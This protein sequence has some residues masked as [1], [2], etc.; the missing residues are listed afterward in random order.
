MIIS[1]IQQQ[2]SSLNVKV[3]RSHCQATKPRKPFRSF[4]CHEDSTT[5]RFT[6]IYSTHI[7]DTK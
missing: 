3:K 7:S 6:S 5:N 2:N 4:T 1:N